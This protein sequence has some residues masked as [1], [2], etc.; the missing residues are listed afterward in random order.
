MMSIREL[1]PV[2]SQVQC[3]HHTNSVNAWNPNRNL[4]GYVGRQGGAV[5][6]CQQGRGIRSGKPAWP[7]GSRVRIASYLRPTSGNVGGS[8]EASLILECCKTG[9]LRNLPGCISSPSV[10]GSLLDGPWVRPGPSR[11]GRKDRRCWMS[12]PANPVCCAG[13][14]SEGWTTQ[15]G[16]TQFGRD[17]QY[18]SVGL[19]FCCMIC[20]AAVFD[21]S[22]SLCL[23]LSCL[24]P[25]SPSFSSLPL[26]LSFS[27]TT[28]TPLAISLLHSLD[29]NPDSEP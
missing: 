21:V 27:N 26:L 1:S 29:P 2:R 28:T 14:R 17:L 6:G 19:A 3:L 25:G 9:R 24:L 22:L 11:S 5:I 18:F 8:M 4:G 12:I 20:L 15:S 13:A 10:L 23:C 7:G 16:N